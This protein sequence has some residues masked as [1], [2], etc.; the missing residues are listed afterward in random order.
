MYFVKRKTEEAGGRKFVPEKERKEVKKKKKG[1][2]RLGKFVL[3]QGGLK[4]L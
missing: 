3:K 4:A 1:M 2:T